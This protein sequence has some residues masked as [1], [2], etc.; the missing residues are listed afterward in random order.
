[1]RHRDVVPRDRDT[2]A[3]RAVEPTVIRRDG[4]GRRRIG[5]E[6]G[7]SVE[8]ASRRVLDS[9]ALIAEEARVVDDLVSS[10]GGRTAEVA[11]L[12]ETRHP[13]WSV[14]LRELACLP[15]GD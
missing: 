7:L 6:P 13:R 4:A 5:L 12:A 1:M 3:G 2:R 14:D 15:D 8:Q 11:Q 10:R 9:R